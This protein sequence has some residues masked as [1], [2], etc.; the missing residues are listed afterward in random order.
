MTGAGIN[1][2][3]TIEVFILSSG[4]GIIPVPYY[5]VESLTRLGQRP[6]R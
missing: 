5:N 4:A 6:T 3:S 2:E 1:P